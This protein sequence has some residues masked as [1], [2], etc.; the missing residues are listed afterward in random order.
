MA[1]AEQSGSRSLAI[2]VGVIAV[3]LGAAVYFGIFRA[4]G[5]EGQLDTPESATP[6]V[7]LEDGTVQEVTP[8]EFEKRLNAGEV[9]TPERGAY[10]GFRLRCLKCGKRTSMQ[11]VHC[12]NDKTPV[13]LVG[14]DGKPGTCP[15]CKW[16]PE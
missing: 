7:C 2:K 12:P 1:S 3:A 10:V 11:A 8:A 16:I 14:R 13:P 6:Y 5:E 9:S 15:K 4:S